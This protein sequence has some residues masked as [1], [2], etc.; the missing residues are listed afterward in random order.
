MYLKSI[1][2]CLLLFQTTLS[3]GQYLNKNRFTKEYQQFRKN[4]LVVA[5]PGHEESDSLIS[6]IF[7]DEWTATT[8]HAIVSRK[9]AERML[10]DTSLSFAFILELSTK[11]D[12]FNPQKQVMA[13]TDEFLNGLI[14]YNGGGKNLSFYNK[15]TDAVGG[16]SFRM[17]KHKVEGKP[18]RIQTGLRWL[19]RMFTLNIENDT[20][21][22]DVVKK[23]TLIVSEK[24][25]GTS[26]GYKKVPAGVVNN[27]PY[28]VKL[29]TPEEADSIVASRSN[30]YVIMLASSRGPEF[31]HVIYDNATGRAL[32]TFRGYPYVIGSPKKQIKRTT[33]DLLEAIDNKK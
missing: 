28:P 9:E 6:K 1:I 15:F 32:C 3:I 25:Y 24:L 5:L 7:R 16:C 20:L 10:K 29:V 27:Y 12:V 18:Y 13:T 19:N 2:T 21:Q 26:F 17:D 33:N 8:I 14:F 30:Q 11:P 22:C 31:G 4:R 23:K